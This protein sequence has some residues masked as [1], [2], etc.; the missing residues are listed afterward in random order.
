M[1][2]TVLVPGRMKSYIIALQGMCKYYTQI[3]QND[4]KTL[5]HHIYFIRSHTACYFISLPFSFKL[6]QA[7]IVLHGHVVVLN[8]LQ[9]FINNKKTKKLQKSS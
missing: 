2:F 6:P 9:H 3:Y 4:L 5:E 7:G 1:V 8:I